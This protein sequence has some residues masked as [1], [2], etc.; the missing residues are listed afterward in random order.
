MPG[1]AAANGAK[2]VN[3]VVIG[4]GLAGLNAAVN[5]EDQG[6][7]V[8][9]L[10]AQPRAGGRL[11]TLRNADGAFECGAT[12]V[13][14]EYGRVRALAE[15][16]GVPLGAGPTD[17]VSRNVASGSVARSSALTPRTPA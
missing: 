4:A 3:V 8:V 14:P 7:K 13:G 15:R 9:L 2:R 16:F 5:L 11:R 1:R 10:E 6:A 12:T 17:L